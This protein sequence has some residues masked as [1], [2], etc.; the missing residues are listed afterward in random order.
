MRASEGGREG[1][2]GV[3][4]ALVGWWVIWLGRLRL[5]CWPGALVWSGGV[6]RSQG[7]GT[8]DSSLRD[9]LAAASGDA[10]PVPGAWR[11][12]GEGPARHLFDCLEQVT[13]L[14]GLWFRF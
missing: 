14:S 5:S 12:P 11:Q 6:H 13:S 2:A 3:G 8:G 4:W 9:Q 10:G 7:W 1:H